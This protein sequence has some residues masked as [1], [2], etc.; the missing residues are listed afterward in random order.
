MMHHFGSEREPLTPFER[1]VYFGLLLLLVG[2]FGAEVFS[3]YQ[4]VKLAALLVVVF[5][6]PLLALH[7][8]GHALM[9]A[10]LGW[11]VGRVVIGVGR[12]V[13]RFQVG[14][15]VVDVKLFPVEGFVQ[16]VPNDLRWP[17]LKS[18]L[19]YFAGPGI[20]LLVLVGIVAVVGLDTLLTRTQ[21]M[22]MITVQSLAVAI[23]VSVIPNLIPHQV[24][25]PNGPIANDGL[26]ILR[27]FY[28]PESHF[29]AQIGMRYDVE[30]DEWKEFD[31]A[32]WWKR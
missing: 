3:N 29:A 19:I 5:W 15:A 30:R 12:L 20:E 11:H 22:G 17:R 21:E 4:P 14:S 16:P 18:A 25:T 31:A 6:A 9:A 13:S 28:L 8:A 23:L 7:E 10:G 27:S 2:L 24:M 1:G 32:D 26:G